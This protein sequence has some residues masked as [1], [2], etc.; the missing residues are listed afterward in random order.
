MGL[1]VNKSSRG[2]LLTLFNNRKAA[3]IPW[4]TGS[5]VNTTFLSCHIAVISKFDFVISH[6]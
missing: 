1:E 6:L 2:L 5:I 3:D 4:L